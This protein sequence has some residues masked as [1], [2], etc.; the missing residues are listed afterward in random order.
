MSTGSPYFEMLTVDLRPMRA[1]V[2]FL[3][4]FLESTHAV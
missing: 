2:T 4:W 1:K 3:R